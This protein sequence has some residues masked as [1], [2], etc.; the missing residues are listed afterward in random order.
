ME[1]LLDIGTKKR[2]QFFSAIPSERTFQVS[3]NS[4]NDKVN[5]ERRIQPKLSTLWA[6]YLKGQ[7]LSLKNVDLYTA[8]P[9]KLSLTCL[10]PQSLLYPLNQGILPLSVDPHVAWPRPHLSSMRLV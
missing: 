6:S 1:T 10:L 4:L 3:W 9:A 8:H 2:R 5:A 7:R